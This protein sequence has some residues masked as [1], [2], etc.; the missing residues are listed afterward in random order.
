MRPVFA[1]VAFQLGVLFEVNE[2]R[3][4]ARFEYIPVLFA[5]EERTFDLVNRTR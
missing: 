1:Q 2:C 4:N 5:R 3:I